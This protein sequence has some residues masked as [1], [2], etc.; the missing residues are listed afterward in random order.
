MVTLD[1]KSRNLAWVDWVI[2]AAYFVLC[3][4]V[5]L[6]VSIISI[7]DAKRAMRIMAITLNNCIEKNK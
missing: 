4:G 6:F 3:I 1:E 7:S 5:G 2:I